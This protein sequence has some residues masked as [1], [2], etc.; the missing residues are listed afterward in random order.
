MSA[1]LGLE[2]AVHRAVYRRMWNIMVGWGGEWELVREMEMGK[3]SCGCAGMR[4]WGFA[5]IRSIGLA[6]GEPWWPQSDDI[7]FISTQLFRILR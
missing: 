2:Y 1:S 3:I 6:V 7:T 4:C 5:W